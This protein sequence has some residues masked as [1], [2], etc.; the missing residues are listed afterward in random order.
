MWFI[1]SRGTPDELHMEMSLNHRFLNRG[2]VRVRV[3]PVGGAAQCPLQCVCETRP[4]YTPQSMYHQA[5]TVDCNEL[6]LQKVPA[7]ISSDTQVT[8]TTHRYFS[9]NTRT[10]ILVIIIIMIRRRII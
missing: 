4:W 8:M 1:D 3:R 10:I 9:I 5:R 6:H 2:L 7:N